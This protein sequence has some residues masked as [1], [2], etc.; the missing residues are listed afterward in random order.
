[1]VPNDVQFN[2]VHVLYRQLGM[3][4][5]ETDICPRKSPIGYPVKQMLQTAASL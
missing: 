4:I 1:M 3:Q 2:S 5:F